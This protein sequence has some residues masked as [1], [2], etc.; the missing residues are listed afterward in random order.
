MINLFRN[1]CRRRLLPGLAV[2][3]LSSLL[4]AQEIPGP[5]DRLRAAEVVPGSALKFNSLRLEI[6]SEGAIDFEVGSSFTIEGWF[7][8]ETFDNNGELLVGKERSYL[9]RRSGSTGR[10][11]FATARNSLGYDELTTI[12][13][14]PLGEWFHLAAVYDGSS[15]TKALY[16]DGA[17]QGEQVIE[18][19]FNLSQ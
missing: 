14:V 1:P 3:A 13:D 4:S 6:P 15:K 19:I 17:L 10:L 18:N 7:R 16:L 8:I 12:D 9:I 11:E 2:L 5:A